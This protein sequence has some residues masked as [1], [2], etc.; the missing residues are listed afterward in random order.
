LAAL[1]AKAQMAET[2]GALAVQGE[3]TGAGFNNVNTMQSAMQRMNF[4]QDLGSLLAEVQISYMGNYGG[5]S[6][7]N[8]SFGG[9]RG[10][11][12]NIVPVSNSEFYVEFFNLDA[13]TCLICKSPNLNAKRV[14]I[15][16]GGD[17][18]GAANHVKLYF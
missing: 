9:F 5:L 4:Q 8:L 2:I 10:M 17:C 3:M 6:K 13:A 11:E 16:D 15:N 7:N 14:D 18:D 12:W 1:P